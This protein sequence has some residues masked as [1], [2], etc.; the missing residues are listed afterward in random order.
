MGIYSFSG[1][2]NFAFIYGF[3][4]KYE[5]SLRNQLFNEFTMDRV[6]ISMPTTDNEF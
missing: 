1:L 2:K 5:F 4:S 3:G 6:D